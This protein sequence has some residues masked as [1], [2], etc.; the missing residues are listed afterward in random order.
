MRPEFPSPSSVLIWF[1]ST[2]KSASTCASN[3]VISLFL[4]GSGAKPLLFSL[5]IATLTITALE[6]RE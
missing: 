2:D 1:F 6:N 5:Y 3:S 4:T